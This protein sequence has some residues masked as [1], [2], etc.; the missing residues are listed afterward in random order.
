MRSILPTD[1]YLVRYVKTGR[2]RRTLQVLEGPHDGHRFDVPS[3]N[4]TAEPD[5][6]C[7]AQIVSR[8]ASDGSQF[9]EVEQML[10]L[11][12]APAWLDHFIPYEN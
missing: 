2:M 1:E 11:G 12:Y 4:A 7:V 8:T 9:N 10:P 5:M 3:S 6:C